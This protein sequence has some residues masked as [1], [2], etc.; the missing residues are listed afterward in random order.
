MKR[1]VGLGCGK[2]GYLALEGGGMVWWVTTSHTIVHY[3]IPHTYHHHHHHHHHHHPPPSFKVMKE[4]Y[5]GG[6]GSTCG[7]GDTPHQ[8]ADDVLC[9]GFFRSHPM[10]FEP[11]Q[12]MPSP[13]AIKAPRAVRSHAYRGDAG[14]RGSCRSSTQSLTQALAFPPTH[15][16]AHLRIR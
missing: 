13:G 11:F 6:V 5:S 14:D 4:A 2:V 9:R 3:V 7:K 15:S 12:N 1:R 10:T 8:D 16:P